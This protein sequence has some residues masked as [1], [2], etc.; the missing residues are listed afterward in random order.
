MIVKVTYGDNE[1][2]VR[3]LECY[4][5][6]FEERSPCDEPRHTEMIYHTLN[7]GPGLIH[8]GKDSIDTVE[9]LDVGGTVDGMVFYPDDE[10]VCAECKESMNQCLNEPM[11]QPKNK[12]TT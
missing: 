5:M 7:H 9:L 6:H 3:I 1:T 12:E 11:F 10:Y 8:L 2:H 4:D